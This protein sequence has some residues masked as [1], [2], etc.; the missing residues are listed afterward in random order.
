LP[1]DFVSTL[2]VVQATLVDREPFSNMWH[3]SLWFS[4]YSRLGKHISITK[5]TVP[6]ISEVRVDANVLR[7][8]ACV[9]PDALSARHTRNRII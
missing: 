4:V 2:F 8:I 1:Q 6:L 9:D 3:H 5:G 7:N